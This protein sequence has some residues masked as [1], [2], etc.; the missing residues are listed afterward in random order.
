MAFSKSGTVIT[1]AGT[2]ADLTGLTAIAGVTR[3]WDGFVTVY[4]LTAGDIL[5]INGT[6]T[7]D[8]EIERLH[9]TANNG[10]IT[11][12]PVSRFNIGLEK[13][14][15]VAD[16]AGDKVTTNFSRGVAITIDRAPTHFYG[17]GDNSITFNGDVVWTGATVEISGNLRF[18]GGPSDVISGT[19]DK[20]VWMRDAVLLCKTISDADIDPQ[21]GVTAVA[22]AG[23]YVGVVA[24]LQ[25]LVPAGRG[26]IS[27][28]FN[29]RYRIDGFT[30]LDGGEILIAADPVSGNNALSGTPNG[31]FS[32]SAERAV[33]A[34]FPNRVT[35]FTINNPDLS[36]KGNF[37]DIPIQSEV[38][39][40][41]TSVPADAVA[42]VTT[43][44]NSAGGSALRIIAGEEGIQTA[45]T[46]FGRD[47]RSCGNV[48]IFR[49]INFNCRN[50]V[51][52]AQLSNASFYLRDFQ[53]TTN[54]RRRAGNGTNHTAN[55]IYTGLITS[56]VLSTDRP[57]LVGEVIVPIVT[58]TNTTLFNRRN[59]TN[60]PSVTDPNTG[61][62]YAMDVRASSNV[63]GDD[64]FPV[65]I[66]QPSHN[67]L[68]LTID[69]SDGSTGTLTIDALMTTDI[70]FT[71]TDGV[72]V[73]SCT[74]INDVYNAV[75]NRKIVSDT[76]R[77]L[78]TTS[79]LWVSES[80]GYLDV[81]AS[82]LTI[83]TGSATGGFT[84]TPTTFNIS[85]GTN[86][87]LVAGDV[88]TGLKSS[89]SIDLE[90]IDLDTVRIESAS[91]T[92]L[93]TALPGG[94]DVNSTFTTAPT[95]DITYAFNTNADVSNLTITHNGTA[96]INIVGKVST[97]FKA[98]NG[99][100]TFAFP[101]QKTIVV[102]LPTLNTVRQIRFTYNG[103]VVTPTKTTTADSQIWTFDT[104]VTGDLKAGVY[105]DKFQYAQL[106]VANPGT[107]GLFALIPIADDAINFDVSLGTLAALIVA[108]FTGSYNTVSTIYSAT[109]DKDAIDSSLQVH[110]AIRRSEAQ[111]LTRRLLESDAGIQWLLAL[112]D[113]VASSFNT[114]DTSG[115]IIN[116]PTKIQIVYDKAETRDLQIN[117]FPRST[118][119][120]AAWDKIINVTTPNLSPGFPS[121]GPNV[122]PVTPGISDEIGDIV[123]S[124]T[125]TAF[126]KT[127]RLIP[128]NDSD[129]PT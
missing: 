57:I 22:Q 11:T 70:L 5:V 21:T 41:Q 2:D 64:T 113:N 37:L 12:G 115:W 84:P 78:P 32:Y 86:T 45:G 117:H 49:D 46:S 114:Y 66:W 120:V 36:E 79:T 105:V 48:I 54:S 106:T 123:V 88:F 71:G 17:F 126:K 65:H 10:A 109:I 59:T 94:F 82:A 34:I 52:N 92:N 13:T 74:N 60:S 97:D 28:F 83:S 98:L 68:P 73:T 44:F 50:G 51:S 124:R 129:F 4:T 119:N 35:T 6:L 20:S 116:D 33:Y 58:G 77:T 111:L 89:T 121:E 69:L 38:G 62:T 14:T 19:N 112:A 31:I 23:T 27:N 53:H 7:I 39:I 108:N 8:P 63:L 81:G 122:T 75:K 95:T 85:I 128:V 24:S 104:L 67:Y 102:T 9:I 15:T 127:S 16:A 103:T 47:G 100:G 87:S 72:N 30:I 91:I 118:T 43:V 42:T 40:G 80:S 76:Q 25:A 61:F 18:P 101:V 90:R 26:W 3:T 1:Q 107:A 93:P 56:G 29:G 110:T 125:S 55:R 99:T 96:T